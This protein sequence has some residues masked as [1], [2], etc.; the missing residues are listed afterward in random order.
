MQFLSDVYLRCAECNGKRY[1]TEVLDVKVALGGREPKSIADVLEMTVADALV[2]FSTSSRR[3]ARGYS[4]SSTSAST[5]STLGQ[6]VPTLSGGEAQRL[7]LAGELAESGDSRK[8]ATL[9]LFDEPTTGLHFADI[10]KLVAAL[11]RLVDAGHSVLVIE[12]NLDVIARRRLG[13]STS[14][15][16][17]ATPAARVV[18]VGTPA[19][20]RASAASH[21]GRALLAHDAALARAAAAPRLPRSERTIFRRCT[22]TCSLEPSG[23]RDAAAAVTSKGAPETVGAQ[24]CAPPSRRDAISGVSRERPSTAQPP[25]H[26]DATQKERR[27]N[28]SGQIEIVHAREHNLRNVD[29]DDPAR[30]VH[31]DHRRQRQRQEHASRSTS[32]SPR[33]SAAI[34]NR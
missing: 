1:R 31:R 5:T 30:Q 34:S 13:R 15:P 7:K 6:P 25:P 10:A 16:K 2:Y 9:F 4:R 23:V 11:E 28:G 18:A 14:D 12:H 29:V 19:D 3:S 27:S 17:A 22:R 33:A 32:C 24:G 8:A 21:T 26:R 20:I